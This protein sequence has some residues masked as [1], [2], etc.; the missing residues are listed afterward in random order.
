MKLCL[1]AGRLDWERAWDQIS[2]VEYAGWVALNNVEPFGED[3][4]DL[5]LRHLFYHLIMAT[6][7]TEEPENVYQ[8]LDYMKL[9][10]KPTAAEPSAKDDMATT[11]AAIDAVMRQLGGG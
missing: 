5:R 7:P 8:A 10:R 1:Q 2:D 4:E 6:S 9:W 11:K 3:R